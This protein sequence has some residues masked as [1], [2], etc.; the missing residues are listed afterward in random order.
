MCYY[1]SCLAVEMRL[2]QAPRILSPSL[3]QW[4]A[5][6]QQAQESD[7][8]TLRLL[9]IEPRGRVG[10]DV[11]IGVDVGTL[12]ADAGSRE[13][14]NRPLRSHEK[15]KCW[16]QWWALMSGARRRWRREHVP[17]GNP[18]T[19]GP[20]SEVWSTGDVDGHV[21]RPTDSLDLAA[22]ELWWTLQT[23]PQGCS[24]HSSDREKT[25]GTVPGTKPAPCEQWPLLSWLIAIQVGTFALLSSLNWARNGV[26]L[27][28]TSLTHWTRTQSIKYSVNT[29]SRLEW[30]KPREQWFLSIR[31][32]F[33]VG[34]AVRLPERMWPGSL[35]SPGGGQH[36]CYTCRRQKVDTAGKLA[37]VAV[38]WLEIEGFWASYIKFVHCWDCTHFNTCFF[39]L[40][41]SIQP[42]IWPWLPG[43][44]GCRV[45]SSPH[46]R[47]SQMSFCINFVFLES[48]LGFYLTRLLKLPC[49]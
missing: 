23:A 31:Q 21:A 33:V 8:L 2:L 38:F 16:Q 17:Q 19:P 6:L 35:C 30:G 36:S 24:A 4:E 1:W 29:L 7:F 42:G 40:F 22:S 41:G 27:S 48:Q 39:R 49:T 46:C 47:C 44:V 25:L 32:V 26:A 37:H 12:Q 15:I 10:D 28:S 14:Q 11:S 3:L 45:K 9:G 18:R 5:I 43:Q 34:P 13:G 20:C